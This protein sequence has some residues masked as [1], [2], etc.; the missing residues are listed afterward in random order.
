MSATENLVPAEG[1]EPSC[2]MAVVFETTV[3]TDS[4]TLAFW[5][6]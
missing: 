1:L 6:G 5:S 4:T 3:Y 2:L